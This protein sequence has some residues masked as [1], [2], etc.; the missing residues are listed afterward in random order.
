MSE[1]NHELFFSCGQKSDGLRRRSMLSKKS[2]PRC[3]A[4]FFRSTLVELTRS[5]NS[6]SPSKETSPTK[7][8]WNLQELSK[9]ERKEGPLLGGT[10]PPVGRSSALEARRLPP[11][12]GRDR[13]AI[14]PPGGTNPPVG[15]GALQHR[16]GV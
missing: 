10:N 5:V 9:K 16:P 3:G 15:S 6:D 12:P 7:F 11:Q 14:H 1:L 4:N 2:P 8:L 13:S